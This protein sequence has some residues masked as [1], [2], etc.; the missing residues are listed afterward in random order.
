MLMSTRAA[1]NFDIIRLTA[2]YGVL[3]SHCWPLFGLEPEP[4][5]HLM[6]FESLGFLC[7]N[8]F[9]FVSGFLVTQSFD[10]HAALRDFA[11]ARL[12]RIL[13]ALAVSTILTAVVLGP[14]VSTLP[15]HDYFRDPRTWSYLGNAL[16]FM[17]QFDLPGVFSTVPTPNSV[18]GSLWTLPLEIAMYATLVGVLLAFGSARL[19]L[20]A[21]CCTLLLILLIGEAHQRWNWTRSG[22]IMLPGI[23]AW[24]FL[25]LG[26]FF[27]AGAVFARIHPRIPISPP[28]AVL[29]SCL[30]LAS[31]HTAAIFTTTLLCGTY[32]VYCFAFSPAIVRRLPRL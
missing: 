31:F 25:R 28:L 10:R 12:T 7:V 3:I 23:P 2:A 13:P 16:V 1:N 20:I 11:I 15:V 30:W 6:G 9:F 14:I 8:V 22:P 29:A 18:N 24:Q 17:P 27:F 26:V 21:F 19:P 32:L 4:I 5:G